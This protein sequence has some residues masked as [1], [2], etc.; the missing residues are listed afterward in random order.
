MA[1]SQP[2]LRAADACKALLFPVCMLS[3][4]GPHP[5]AGQLITRYWL[6]SLH[7]GRRLRFGA[8]FIT[9]L[10][11]TITELI[12]SRFRLKLEIPTSA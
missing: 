1:G 12:S 3:I 8:F 9:V 5:P 6:L 7:D 4:A 10:V 11:R 2:H